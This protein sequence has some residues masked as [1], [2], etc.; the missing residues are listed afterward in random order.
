MG[1]AGCRVWRLAQAAACC[2]VLRQEVEHSWLRAASRIDRIDRRTRTTEQHRRTEFS[3]TR[4]RKSIRVSC[5]LPARQVGCVG[6]RAQ[7]ALRR[8]CCSDPGPLPAP[9]KHACRAAV[10]SAQ[11]LLAAGCCCGSQFPVDPACSMQQQAFLL[12]CCVLRLRLPEQLASALT[13]WHWRGNMSARY[14]PKYR[15]GSAGIFRLRP[16]PPVP[17]PLLAPSQPLPPSIG[18]W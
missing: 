15:T 18:R 17:P 3:P 11:W 12:R 8:C 2:C 6:P 1:G 7:Q 5:G 13:P 10:R 16:T 4:S 9:A 14:S